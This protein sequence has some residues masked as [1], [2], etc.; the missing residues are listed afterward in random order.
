[1][2]EKIKIL[3][4]TKVM[5][6][7]QIW[8]KK[9]L[10]KVARSGKLFSK[11]FK[12]SR[13]DANKT[14]NKT[15]YTYGEGICYTQEMS[16]AEDF[17]YSKNSARKE[18]NSSFNG[19]S[20]KISNHDISNLSAKE[21]LI[22]MRKLTQDIEEIDEKIDDHTKLLETYKEKFIES[23]TLYEDRKGI[24][25]DLIAFFECL[26]EQKKALK[27]SYEQE[28]EKIYNTYIEKEFEKFQ[29]SS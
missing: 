28:K 21:D 23:K 1:M 6:R 26:G 12:M 5:I 11:N 18:M 24:I 8:R 13:N 25:D 9:Q 19:P 4:D 27:E 29:F 2:S 14:F 3:E 16:P 7:K 15:Q 17:L 22:E 10:Y 20:L